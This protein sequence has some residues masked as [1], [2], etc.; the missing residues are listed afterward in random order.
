MI[1]NLQGG[2]A[3]RKRLQDG[4]TYIACL[5]QSPYPTTSRHLIQLID[6]LAELFAQT[7]GITL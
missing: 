4:E 3:E 7:D 1:K 6:D 2:N 5:Q